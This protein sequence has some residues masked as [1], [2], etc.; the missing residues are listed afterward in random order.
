MLKKMG[1]GAVIYLYISFVNLSFSKAKAYPPGDIHPDKNQSAVCRL[2][3]NMILANNYKKVAINDSLSV[4]VFDRYLKSLDENHSYLLAVDVAAFDQ[5]KTLLD[6][7]LQS[8]NLAHVFGMFN[9]F[10]MRNEERLKYALT[11]LDANYDFTKNDIYV[12]DRRKLPFIKTEADMNLMWNQRVKYDLLELQ[13]SSPDIAK[14]RETLKKKYQNLLDQS[15]KTSSQDVFQLFMNAFTA[16]VD[17]HAAYFNPFNASQFNVGITRALEGIGATLA[18]SNEYVTIKSLTP[19]GPAYKT[20]LINPED[21]IIAIA[22]GKDGDFQDVTGWRLDNAIALI[23]GPKGTIVKLKVLAKGKSASDEPLTVEV[24]RDKIILEDQSAKQEIRTYKAMGKN[25]KI[26]IISIPAFY[27]DHVAYTAGDRNY[28]STTRD[29]K[30]LLDTLKQH[31]VDGIM[32]D[33]RGNGGGSLN[34]AVSLTGLF[35]KSGPVV[36]VR[37]VDQHIQ[38]N[39]DFDPSIYYNGPLAVLVD[40]TSASASEIFS[41]AIQDYG[42]GLILGS[43]TY[44]KGSVQ[45]TVD[46]NKVALKLAGQNKTNADTGKQDQFGQLNVTIG[47]FYR[48]NGSSTQHKGVVPDIQLPS[49]IAPSKYGEDNEPS[50]M[51]W[52]TISKTDYIPVGLLNKVV[53][54]LNSQYQKRSQTIAAYQA[55]SNEVKAY[56]DNQ[57]PKTISLNAQAF[58]HT[59]D[60]NAKKALDRDNKLRVAIGLPALKKGEV[61]AKT[62]DL[63]FMKTEGAQILTD[64]IFL[65]KALFGINGPSYYPEGKTAN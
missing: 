24:V 44:G 23:R 49:F 36:Q 15:A 43:Q 45:T 30:L 19:G 27:F 52:D 35:I 38:V 13:L 53:P 39:Q 17:P 14:N 32:I 31:N 20:K 8:G 26:G 9:V 62:D 55:Y 59:R 48:I 41:G 57:G 42:R 56:Q 16:S 58:K 6:D 12:P 50:A 61:K 18:L 2:V 65:D 5:Y 29:V 54:V 11:Q 40:R 63:D 1:L 34:E 25:V 28:K 60:V 4:L 46:L 7:D 47:K 64:Y 37:D 10:K 33:L 51:P 21:R 22:Q 3:V